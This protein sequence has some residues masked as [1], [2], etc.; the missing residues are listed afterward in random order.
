MRVP[1]VAS[2]A[3]RANLMSGEGAAGERRQPGPHDLHALLPGNHDCT[4]A[5]RNPRRPPQP[6]RFGG[7]D[8]RGGLRIGSRL[9][10]G[11]RD[12]LRPGQEP[13]RQRAAHA[14]A[15]DSRRGRRSA[16]GGGDQQP[17]VHDGSPRDRATIT[18][19]RSSTGATSG[20]GS[21]SPSWSGT[22]SGRG[23][24]SSTPAACSTA[25]GRWACTTS[26]TRSGP[27]PAIPPTAGTSS[28]WERLGPRGRALDAGAG[29]PPAR[30]GLAASLR[31]DLRPGGAR[32]RQGILAFG[33]GPAQP[34]GRLLRVRRDAAGLRLPLGP[35]PG[36]HASSVWKTAARSSSRHLPHRL[37]ARN[38]RGDEREHHRHRQD[39]GQRHQAGRPDAALLRGARSLAARSWPAGRS[40]G[41]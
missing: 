16:D 24:C 20:W 22:A 14:A 28:G 21:S 6:L 41:S 18:T 40:P 11:E 15:P 19:P 27:S 31:R 37:V 29:L 39:P 10:A 2:A 34:P 12:R 1:P 25:F 38:S 30:P 33:D 26:S 23:S 32:P 3:G 36:A 4:D 35:G 13:L 9:P 17:P 8:R 5:S 7:A